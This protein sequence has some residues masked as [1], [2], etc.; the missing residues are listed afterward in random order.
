MSL[1]KF[2][3][4]SALCLTVLWLLSPSR[5]I[6][7]TDAGVVEITYMGPGGPIS[8]PM[9]DAVKE[10][11]KES[12]EAHAKDPSQPVYRVISGQN[13]ASDQTADPTRF[14]VSVAGGMPPDVIYFDRFAVSQWAAKGVFQRLDPYVK[15]DL[16]DK[17]PD[18]IQPKDYFPSS[19]EE[20]TYKDPVTGK[21]GLYGIPCEI[22][23]RVLFYNEDMLKQAGFVDAQG[24][25]QPPRT[26]EELE[27]MA[28]ALTKRGPDGRL[29]RLG[30]IP[31]YGDA[32]LYMYGWMNGGHFMSPDRRRCTLNDPRIVQALN[33]MTRVYDEL[34]GAQEVYAFQAGF[35]KYGEEDPFTIGKVAMVIDGYWVLPDLTH[36]GRYL[37]WATAPPPLPA[38]ELA[39]GRQP[40]S[41]VSGWCYAIPSTSKHKAAAWKLIRFLRSQKAVD[42]MA[43]SQRLQC[44]SQGL[45]FVP[46]QDPDMKFNRELD[47]KYIYGDPGVDP[48]LKQAVTVFNRFLAGSPFRPVTP[49]GQL[50]WNQQLS[51]TENAIFHKMTAQQ[52]LDRATRTVQR[53]LDPMLKPPTG[54]VVHWNWI[55]YL[56][57]ALLIL[58]AVGVFL[59]D[60]RGASANV[61]GKRSYFRGQWR[62]GWLCAL[63]WIAGFVVFTGGP[64][65]FSIVISFTHY[66]VLN[67]ARFAGLANYHRLFFEDP[68]FWKSLW[69]TLY[70]VLGVPLGLA[71]GLGM[72][73]LL[74]LKLKGVALWRTFFYLPSIIP[75]VASSILW[76]WILNPNG[77]LL[78]TILAS[79]GIH[80]PN[81]LQDENTSKLSLIL[82]GLWSSGAGMI[83]W[84]AG[85]KGI[86]ESYYEA[87]S[88]D[89]ASAI[90]K[91][92]YVT[93]PMLSPYILFN[94]IIGLIGTFQI[95]TQSY[96]MTSGGPLN[97]TLF[98]VY[99]LF[100][101]A[102]R[103]MQMGY[104]AA[105][106]W[107]LFLV[108]FGL[109]MAQLW[110]AERWVHY[111]G[112]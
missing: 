95:F 21:S 91:F 73:L 34:G 27:K 59:W 36:F 50:M 24:R 69:N 78:N 109:T 4:A 3:L 71:L 89:G 41:W 93:I 83:I 103:Y 57:V 107:I 13:A 112:D 33:W 8:G 19:W 20:A 5:S 38:A 92:F 55:I 64:I 88:L 30:F 90:Q 43:E 79:V 25:A 52:A 84:L 29:D 60:T 23:D 45:P 40:I 105:M 67:P 97:S 44:A 82:M 53:Q 9:D 42:I 11:E 74:N 99:Y 10:F 12:V 56:Y 86:S 66:D 75:V 14:L 77:G 48:K 62:D 108:V 76:L 28:V 16:A 72:A 102:F 80:G 106:A 2:M 47:A 65:L 51:A 96:I 22:D 35:H 17:V 26:W 1:W 6:R 58:G 81:W 100:N 31:N 49:V 7:A 15:K 94:V 111:E 37:H 101:C 61:E 85:L 104:A 39:R 46:T 54:Q 68:L 110:M 98:Y 63:P 87:A 32:W 18:A 70:M